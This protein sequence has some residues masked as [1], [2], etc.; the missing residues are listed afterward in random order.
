MP[1]PIVTTVGALLVNDRNE[2]LLGLRAAWQK[3]WPGHWD[4]VGGRVEPGE[5]LEDTLIR[6]V[7]EEIGVT[8]IEFAW[9]DCIEERRPAAHG[10]HLHHIYTVTAWRGGLEYFTRLK[11]LLQGDT[12]V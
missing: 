1:T 11:C 3:A 12:T 6:E 7:Q 4:A 8:P 9:P 10:Q 2:I 5:R